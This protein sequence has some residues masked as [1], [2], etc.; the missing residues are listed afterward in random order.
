[1]WVRVR[2]WFEK[3]WLDPGLAVSTSWAV[4]GQAIDHEKHDR[5]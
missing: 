1:V 3:A 5:L 2:S 4:C